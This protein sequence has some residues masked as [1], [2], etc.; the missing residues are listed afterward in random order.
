MVS[1]WIDDQFINRLSVMLDKFK[2]VKDNLYNFR[3]PLCGDSQKNKSKARGYFYLTGDSYRFQCHNCGDSMRVGPFIQL[4]AP[5]M[6]DEYMFETYKE[7]SKVKPV[8]R[9]LESHHKEVVSID[10]FDLTRLIDMSPTHPA[11]QYVDGRQI[12]KDKQELLYYQPKFLAWVKKINNGKYKIDSDHPRLVFPYFD[13]DGSVFRFNSRCFGREDPKYQQT[14]LDQDKPRLY[15][16]ERATKFLPL[17]VVEGNID[18]L[19][20]PNC[21]A[22]GTANYNVPY[23]NKFPERIYV[24][25]NQPRNPE[26]VRQLE[27]IVESGQKVCLWNENYGGKDINALVTNGLTIKEIL[28]IIE[29]SSYSGI[30]AILKF[31]QWRK[32]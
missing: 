9:R 20:L 11:R 31:K 30:E 10:S 23:L 22:V 27:P 25:D 32:D 18:S 21:V 24:P 8:V 1:V 5:M 29:D 28:G 17:Y 4:V 14:V 3:C 16:L 12:P 6:Y 19:F 15:G 7:G 13:E 26:V 2:R